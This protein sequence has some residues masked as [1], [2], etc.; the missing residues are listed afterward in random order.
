MSVEISEFEVGHVPGLC[1]FYNAQIESVPHC[2]PVSA[3]WFGEEMHKA[4]GLSEAPK[5]FDSQ[6]AQTSWVLYT[7]QGIYTAVEIDRRASGFFCIHR[8]AARSDTL[9]WT[10]RKSTWQMYLEAMFWRSR[11]PSDTPSTTVVRPFS[12]T[13]WVMSKPC[14]RCVGSSDFA[15]RCSWTG[16]T[17]RV[18]IPANPLGRLRS[19]RHARNTVDAYPH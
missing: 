19:S 7:R 4:L 3:E 8:D 16:T 9:C 5:R 14:S 17:T 12:R 1:A 10:G 15:G 18:S 11:N 2:Y 13:D 6:K